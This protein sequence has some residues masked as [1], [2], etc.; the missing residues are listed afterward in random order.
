MKQGKMLTI[1]I[2]GIFLVFIIMFISLTPVP[3][4]EMPTPEPPT[5]V[6]NTVPTTGT[7]INA[8][9][10]TEPVDTSTTPEL[11]PE[12]TPTPVSVRQVMGTTTDLGAG[13]FIGGTDIPIGIYD[14]TSADSS[15]NFT[16]NS[17]TG[18]LITN[19]VLGTSDGFGVSK[20]RVLIMTG[21]SI[22]IQG[23]SK[24]HFEP[25]TTSFITTSQ[26]VSLYSGM[27]GVG[28]DIGVGRYLCTA[29]SGS[30]N[31]IVY[32]KDGTLVTNEILGGDT[33]VKNITVDLA[34][35]GTIEISGINQVDFT[36]TN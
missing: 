19:E 17:D 26:Q 14:A 12:P 22:H 20:V 21:Y 34:D 10:T 36:P 4:A 9:A 31:L 1:L 13:T 32:D 16:M 2:V 6:T 15:G 23:I 27:F 25:V 28:Q 5:E 18:A 8:N 24:V 33:G 11:T 7:G 3:V 29:T 35:E 30:G